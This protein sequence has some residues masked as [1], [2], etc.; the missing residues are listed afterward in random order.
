MIVMRTYLPGLFAVAAVLAACTGDEPNRTPSDL[1]LVSGD[2]QT[3]G[4]GLPLP[5]GLTVKVVDKGGHGVGGVNVA[6]AVTAGGGSVQNATVITL[7]NG[8]ATT[9]WTVGTAVGA[10]NTATAAA[11][12]LGGSPIT[13]TATVVA[14][15]ASS[16]VI[17][18]GDAQDGTVGQD[19]PVSVVAA[20]TDPY[21]NPA[22]NQTITWVVTGGGGTIAV[23]SLTTDGQGRGGATWTLGYQLG[24]Q[25]LQA[26]AGFAAVNAT[27]TAALSPGATLAVG[28]GDG[29]QG[30]AGQS[31]LAPIG[32]RVRTADGHGL[33]NVQ[34]DWSVASG[35]GSVAQ[36]STLTDAS[37][38]ALVG[39]TLGASLGPQTVTASNAGLSPSSVTLNASAVV[40]APSSIVGSVGLVDGQLTSLRASSTRAA[41]GPGEPIRRGFAARPISRDQIPDELLVKFRAGA[42]GAPSA[43]RAMA[44]VATARA[45]AQAMQDRLAAH[46]VAGKVA[47]TGLSPVTRTARLKVA[48]PSSVDSVVRAVVGDPAVVAV[49]HNRRMRLAGG[50]V[51]PGTIPNDPNFPN[52]SWHY[53]MV[54]LPRAWSITTGSPSTIV[55]VLDDG[56]VFH[57]PAIGAA[58]AT[59]LT[60]GGNLRNDGYDFVSPGSVPLCAGGSIDNAGDGG[61]YDLDPS[62]PDSRLQDN[63]ICLGGKD[64]LG[65][66]GTHVAGTIGA[67]GN[68][69]TMVTGVNWAV[70]IRPVRV[71]GLQYGDLF[72]IQ[73]G[74]LYASGFPVMGPV[75][76][77]DPP[78]Q[79]ARIINM[80]FGGDC[81]T[82]TDP[83]PIHDAILAVT[84]PG[85]PNGGV[86]VVAAAGN[87]ASS[88]PFCPAA[89]P[90]VLS[91]AAVGPSGH[92]ASFSNWGS[93]VDIAAP[94]GEFAPPADG[95]YGIFSSVCDFTVSP[96]TPL[97]ARYFGTSMASPHVAGIAAL[98]LAQNPSLTPVQLRSLLTTYAS[99][100]PAAEQLGAGIVNARNALTQ[101]LAPPRQLYVRAMDIATGATTATVA[102][103][104]G[105]YT[106][107]N[108][109]D[110]SYYVVAG[111]DEAGDGVTGLPGR[112]FG[113]FGGIA[114]PTPVAVSA[115]TG[116]FAAFSI[117]FPV[118]K[119]PDDAAAQ[120]SRLELDGAMEG[121][122]TATDQADVYRIQ[123][124]VAGTYSFETTG[125]AGAF[126][127]FALDLNTTLALT[128]SG[129]GVLAQSTDIDPANNNY[130]SRI[131]TALAAGTYYLRVTPGDFFGLGPHVGRYTLAGQ[132]VP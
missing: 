82:G 125:F 58:G 70:S 51:R 94:G 5:F 124:P 79:P 30:L 38:A 49:G 60:G 13:F 8:I 29:Q 77:I 53:G 85:L 26:L 91:V 103:A 113:A 132:P 46:A 41:I 121:N 11:A 50:P 120:A 18:Q 25:T 106:L 108:L 75:G 10:V 56:I 97:V 116:G 59:Y 4:A 128:D 54:D 88:A 99:P 112:R 80:S 1:V 20:F 32:V 12:S 76:M 15:P 57:H 126:C 36:P 131:T 101:T 28:S 78:S 19:L 40:P 24:G 102:A 9:N 66:H 98:L 64:P 7:G 86:L 14:A 74:I 81:P 127:S 22:S 96:C 84:D 34:V 92:R 33:S 95:T 42:V 68:D 45:V 16:G 111:E 90:E 27:A 35:G 2:G 21:G 63:P 104:G 52:Q 105:N 37:G 110:G 6:F 73:N 69:A 115:S 123:I 3:G 87:D 129:D 89:Y 47:V 61:G 118:E 100:L 23:T 71:I 122:I 117:G 93:T 72:D 65:G 48:D 39:W 114:A 130:C 107:S 55:A 17:V 43:V 31:L 83:D 119:E 62:V 44:S 67:K 109:P